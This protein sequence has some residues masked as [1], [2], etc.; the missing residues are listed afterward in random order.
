MMSRRHVFT[1]SATLGVLLMMTQFQ[2]CG[3][4][5]QSGARGASS[6]GSHSADARLVEDFNKVEI[7]F[8]TA[9]V[10]L[11]DEA[12]EADVSGLCNRS[13]NG[14][15][16]KWTIWAGTGQPLLKGEST[17]AAGGFDLQLEHLDQVI[18]GVDHQLLV[19][20]DW[21]GSAFTHLVRRCQP[22]ASEPLPA[23]AA[24][25]PAGTTC[26]LEYV[27][28]GDEPCSQVCYRQGQVMSQV[29]VERVQCSGLAAK[30]AGP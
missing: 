20:G 29:T 8:A 1:F 14:A 30:L 25:Q 10:Q 21:G 5:A 2:N 12:S 11:H 13:H 16:L 15:V 9:G 28:S 4:A 3:P 17:C 7:Q 18:C 27:P 22:L 24:N 6:S 23:V 19:E 26:A